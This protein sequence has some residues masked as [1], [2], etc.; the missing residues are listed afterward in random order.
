MYRTMVVVILA[1][2][3]LTPSVFGFAQKKASTKTPISNHMFADNIRELPAPEGLSPVSGPVNTDDPIGELFILGTTWWDI[4]HNNTCGRQV[5]IDDMG[6]IHATWMNGLNTGATYRH[7]FYQLIDPA[8]LVVFPGGVQVDQA[9]R[10]GFTDLELH[11]DGR[12]MPCFHQQLATEPLFHTAL[13]FDYFP[14]VGAFQSQDAPWFYEGAT[15]LE[16]I[17]PKV[18][19][20]RNDVYHILSYENPPGGTT[21]G[22]QRQFYISARYDPINFQ[23]DF[24]DAQIPF[25]ESTLIAQTVAASPVSDRVALA[26]YQW[27]A[28]DPSDSTSQHDNDVIVVISEDGV[29][30]DFEETIN[31][32][33]WI[34]PEPIIPPDTTTQDTLIANRDTLRAYSSINLF[35]DYDD[36]L[37]CIFDTEAYWHYEGTVSWGN[38]FIWH[39]DEVNQEYNMVANGWFDNGFY[40]PGVFNTYTTRPQAAIDPETE[41]I[42]CMYQ[43]YFQPLG[44]STQYGYPYQLGDTTDFSAGG[45]P[46]GEIWLTVSTNGGITWAEGTN[47]TNTPSPEAAAGD[48][49]SELT[50]CMAPD[51]YN[52]Q[53]H[54][55]YVLDRDAGC[56]IQTEG[57][58]TEN[59]VIYQRVPI[60]AVETTP[61]LLNFPMHV[62]STGYTGV[63]KYENSHLP[64][65]FVLYPP[66]PNPF[67]NRSVVKFSLPVSAEVSLKVYDVQGREAAVLEDG[68]LRAGIYTRTFNG[69]GLASGVYFVKLEAG[70][71]TRVHKMV[72][73]K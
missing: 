31:V 48:C 63:G 52:D 42:Y 1:V 9:T 49:F 34:P 61:H 20:D 17:W 68:S 64:S 11:S 2:V 4:Q 38:G 51:I 45:W 8:G 28:T 32:T 58:W 39:W 23:I 30:W 50:P 69:E 46:N 62:D 27:G 65:E 6:Y 47:V 54:I 60:S 10:S 19:K 44:P 18:A 16:V 71:E 56:V 70:L 53:C 22:H 66:C 24:D 21:V 59:E 26:L 40:N 43:R 73:V 72:M 14:R 67:N 25:G 36:V 37:H 15:D 5:Q 3:F 13:A 12:A 55:L 7:I 41:Y 35:F 57:T 29:T 33:N